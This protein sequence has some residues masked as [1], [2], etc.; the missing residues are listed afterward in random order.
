MNTIDIISWSI[1][2][3]SALAGIVRG[4]TREVLGISAWIGALIASYMF[5]PMIKPYL[6]PLIQRK[7]F[8]DPACLIVSFIG[9]FFILGVMFKAISRTIRSSVLGSVDRSLGLI[10]GVA[11]GLIVLLCAYV[12]VL[13]FLPVSKQPEALRGALITK[14]LDISLSELEYHTPDLTLW[15]RLKSARQEAASTAGDAS[16][17]APSA[18]EISVTKLA[19]SAD[20]APVHRLV[21]TLSYLRAQP[22]EQN[23]KS[24]GYN[25]KQRQ[26]MDQL[27]R[28]RTTAIEAEPA[29]QAETPADTPPVPVP[30]PPA[31]VANDSG[32]AQPSQI[33]AV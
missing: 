8:L 13:F 32:A 7:V 28:S 11:R 31:A 3:L 26:D 19:M 30:H 21:E 5:A 23:A 14:V 24:Q 16:E 33:E 17:Q 10:F 25:Q 2:G 15:Q 18:D 29:A 22:P 27:V 12:L 4:F 9:A 20:A 6:D 1:L